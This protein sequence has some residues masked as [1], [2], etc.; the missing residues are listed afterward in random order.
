MNL[1]QKLKLR[2][3]DGAQWFS[4]LIGCWIVITTASA[5]E[6][7]HP[8]QPP[9]RSSPRAALKTF[10]DS[11]DALGAFMAREYLPSP[12]R[13]EFQRMVTLGDAAVHCLDLSAVPKATRVKTGRAAAIALYATLSRIQLP[14]P[15]DIPGAGQLTQPAGTN[16]ARWVIPNTQIALERSASGPHSD[17][18]LFSADTVAKA[19][20]YYERVKALPYTR[21][22]P[23]ENVREIV[24]TGG[25]W[26]IPYRWV[27]GMPA[28]LRAPLVG[29]ASWKW[30]ALVLMMGVLSWLLRWVYRLSRGGRPEHPFIRALAL[31]SLPIFLLLAIPAVAY[32]A[33]AQLNMTGGVANVIELLATAI[34]FLTGAALSWRLAS[35]AAEAIIASPHI[36]PESI[37]AHL[38]RICTRLLGIVGAA[39]LLAVGADRL[40]MPV[41]GIVAGLGVGGLAVALAAQSTIENLIG[42]L[43]LF[44]DRPMQ[45]GD[46]CRCGSDEGTI[47]TIGIRSTRIRGTD[48]TLTTIPN[49]ALSK[50]SIV[51]LARR[52]RMLMQSVIGVRYETSEEQLRY[53]LV[54]I[55]EMLLSHPCIQPD[56][57]RARFINFGACSL[58]IEVF[59]YVTT[60]DR[61][62]FLAVREDL[63]LRI[64]DIVKESGTGFA[65]PSQTLYFG[66]DDGLDAGRTKVAEAQVRQW[67]DEGRLPFPDFSAE[68][69]RQMRGAVTHPPPGSSSEGS[70]GKLENT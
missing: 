25:G 32:L 57:A 28:W 49:A 4:V 43:N 6:P 68:Q 50:M 36:A 52:D 27:Q 9:D 51:N 67:R 2:H 1:Q 63:F 39:V 38:I 7:L 69:A 34:M 41:Y 35:L 17:E 14:A 58:D 48:R 56:S 61:A 13:A 22:V 12:S 26:M 40:G 46:F 19:E 44:A 53:L 30:I 31:C 18:F 24:A 59:A 65:F 21:S 3:G 33:L 64:M 66:R 42:G 8:L 45:V 55:R 54:K 5:Q 70:T 23:L 62:E 20:S 29:Q 37:D 47:E 10:F 16:F 11:A 15:D 60:R